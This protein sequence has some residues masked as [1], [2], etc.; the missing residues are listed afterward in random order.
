LR[1]LGAVIEKRYQ[2]IYYIKGITIIDT[3][4]VVTSELPPENHSSL[5]VL[6]SQ[7][8]ADD[9]RR[10]IESTKELRTKG[11][12]DNAE[13]VLQVSINANKNLYD[14]L[15]EDLNMCQALQ[16]LMKEEIDT[17]VSG[18]VA[19]EI[20]KAE[21]KGGTKATI[22]LIKALMETSNIDV[23]EAMDRLQIAQ[24]DREELKKQMAVSI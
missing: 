18:A 9:A 3:Q 24:E 19:T 8:D 1:K 2:G 4:I 12:R 21:A 17:I 16:E 10:F 20:P 15:K 11:D 23:T 5:R 22:K 14:K 6:S 13:A 7:A